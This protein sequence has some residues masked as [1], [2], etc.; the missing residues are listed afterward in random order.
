MNVFLAWSQ[1]RSRKVA[2]AL[3]NWLPQVIQDLEPWM[4]EK[5]IGKGARWNEE[6]DGRLASA[7]FGIICLT[8]ENVD[9]TWLH[10]EAGALSKAVKEKAAVCPYLLGLRKTDVH[11]PLASFQMAQGEK[12]DT[13]RLIQ[14][15]NKAKDRPLDDGLLA[16]S[17]DRWWPDFEKDIREIGAE[18]P[19]GPQRAKRSQQ[20]VL[21]EILT[22]VRTLPDASARTQEILEVVRDLRLIAHLQ[23]PAAIGLVPPP[24]LPRNLADIGERLGL[25]RLG[26]KPEA[27]RDT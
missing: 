7:K 22:I 9:S 27:P 8:P 26:Q 13:S 10:F 1:E 20:E 23:C 15:V 2:E 3:H 24:R 5:D 4:S 21:E 17:F 14:S 25:G 16:T 18:Q 12:E 6:I 19:A 11:G